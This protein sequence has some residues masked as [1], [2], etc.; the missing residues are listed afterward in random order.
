MARYFNLSQ[1]NS[2]THPKIELPA[3]NAIDWN[4][5]P[6][7]TH[8]EK[9]QYLR[10]EMADLISTSENPIYDAYGAIQD[11]PKLPKDNLVVSPEH[12]I[13]AYTR[14]QE[15]KKYVSG[16]EAQQA[17]EVLEAFDGNIQT[18]IDQALALFGNKFVPEIAAMFTERS[19][20]LKMNALLELGPEYD[21]EKK[22]LVEAAR[23]NQVQRLK[24]SMT[25][26]VQKWNTDF[27]L[28]LEQSSWMFNHSRTSDIRSLPDFDQTALRLGNGD[29]KQGA[30]ILSNILLEADREG[31]TKVSNQQLDDMMANLWSRPEDWTPEFRE[32]VKDPSM[33]QFAA[34]TQSRI[35]KYEVSKLVGISTLNFPEK[36]A[37]IFDVIKVPYSDFDKKDLTPEQIEERK[38]VKTYNR[39]NPYNLQLLSDLMERAG[40]IYNDNGLPDFFSPAFNKTELSPYDVGEFGKIKEALSENN[41]SLLES[42]DWIDHALCYVA[43]TL[44]DKNQRLWNEMMVDSGIGT[45]EEVTDFLKRKVYP[46]P[47]FADYLLNCRSKNERRCV[48]KLRNTFGLMAVPY[49]LGMPILDECNINDVG[50]QVDFLIPCDLISTWRVGD[51]G[52]YHPVI[53]QKHVFVGEYFGYDRS[54]LMTIN[55]KNGEGWNGIAGGL[56][57]VKNSAG[58]E[59][60][61]KNGTIVSIG[62][63]YHQRTAWKKMT[64]NFYAE[65][66]GNK[67]IHIDGQLRD[68]PIMA[69]LD[70]NGIL[71]QTSVCPIGDSSCSIVLHQLQSHMEQG[72][73]D[74]NCDARK[75]LHFDPIT[76]AAVLNTTKYSPDEAYVKCAITDL[77]I[78]KGMMPIA[79]KLQSEGFGREQIYAY[80]MQKDRADKELEKI[81]RLYSIYAQNEGANSPNALKQYQVYVKAYQAVLELKNEH[82]GRA[83]DEYQDFVK[84]N[85]KFN[86]D[87]AQLQAILDQI[88][89]AK[90][91]PT[92]AIP[93]TE[94]RAMVMKIVKPYVPSSNQRRAPQSVMAQDLSKPRFWY[95]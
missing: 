10:N 32:L 87:L 7:N 64:E 34:E 9:A 41:L 11:K 60:D 69:E 59:V 13:P 95:R 12:M 70:R 28:S 30:K 29:V 24:L 22:S 91:D 19:S 17:A 53:E 1:R 94:I 43:Q 15:I 2:A 89:A 23:L 18:V 14:F 65:S 83:A 79:L 45:E 88:Q 5:I 57:K 49:T 72:C 44:C 52:L 20:K 48:E 67:S 42:N 75:Y 25:K 85:P 38:K 78:Q 47:L 66:S 56:A 81:W 33:M 74:P 55:V 4:A 77:Q 8:A 76:N 51:D 50:F 61:A 92:K 39:K 16:L 6:G 3:P 82:L 84:N 58:E 80:Y 71:Y 93:G 46:D 37:D 40:Y 26:V 21:S 31:S 54:Q 62:E 36:P 90:T 35:D 86:E 73:N 63:K 27:G 68:R